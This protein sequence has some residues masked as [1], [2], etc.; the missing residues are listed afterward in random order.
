M[1]I[2]P[3][4]LENLVNT[5]LASA[6]TDRRVLVTG[7]TGFK[8]SWLTAW[9]LG[10]G[11]RVA[12]FSIGIPSDPSHFSVL[13][14][15][16][17]IRDYRGDIRNREELGR[18]FD[19]YKPEIVFHLAA[20][21]LVRRSYQ[22]PAAT[23][24]VNT[25][26]TLNLLECLRQRPSVRA[27]VLITSD[28]CYR[29]V[30]WVWGYR[31]EDRLGGEDPYSGSKGCAELVFYSYMH[32][33]FKNR[34][35]GPCLATARAGNVIGGGDWAEDRIV[36]DCMR[37]WSR[38]ETV[39]IRSPRSTRPWQHVLEPLSGYLWLGSEL[40]RKNR[41]AA[42]SSYNFGPDAMVNPSVETLIRELSRHWPDARWAVDA[43]QAG[44]ERPEATLLKLC[45]DKALAELNWKATLTFEETIRL[46]SQWYREYYNDPDADMAACTRRQID[47][48][49]DLARQRG[50]P[51]SGR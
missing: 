13:G 34:P 1:A 24:E 16:K 50:L 51:W 17:Q 37:S 28:K 10:L 40:W 38:G 35:D 5:M 15:E 43:P 44:A 25:L 4:A 45:C 49:C 31:E 2:R 9:L 39:T 42:C 14:L 36:P 21:A 20:Q 3:G 22:D 47:A 19:E 29:N 32:S 8:G 11:A 26:G 12:G 33:F 48:Y 41:L 46:T 27:G 6:Y 18:V 23:F 7:H 30:E